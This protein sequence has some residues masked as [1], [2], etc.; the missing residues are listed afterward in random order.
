MPVITIRHRNLRDHATTT[1][2]LFLA[3]GFILYE[4]PL[5]RLANIAFYYVDFFFLTATSR[6]SSLKMVNMFMY[7]EEAYRGIAM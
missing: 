6:Q 2:I 7:Y 5:N 4:R 1:H 3:I